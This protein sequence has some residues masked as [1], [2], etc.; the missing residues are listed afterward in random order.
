M[1]EEN[2]TNENT[3]EFII[4]ACKKEYESTINIKN[5]YEEAL[6]EIKKIIDK[7]IWP[8][9]DGVMDCVMSLGRS[10]T[11]QIFNIVNEVLIG[12]DK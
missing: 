6:L 3:Y 10:D 11:K 9:K 5:R 7:T 4:N 1:G 8:N 2:K 12:E